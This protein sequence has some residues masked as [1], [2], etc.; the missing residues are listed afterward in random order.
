MFVNSKHLDHDA[1]LRLVHVTAKTEK[2]SFFSFQVALGED[3][4]TLDPKIFQITCLNPKPGDRILDN[5]KKYH[6][7]IFHRKSFLSCE[8]KHHNL[9]NPECLG[10]PT[11]MPLSGIHLS[12][13]SLVDKMSLDVDEGYALLVKSP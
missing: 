6:T 9:K 7:Y 1:P 3:T 11:S 10:L 5:I 12:F 4:L 2:I 13:D 8:Q